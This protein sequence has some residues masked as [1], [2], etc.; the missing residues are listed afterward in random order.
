MS[1]A[2][3]RVAPDPPMLPVVR[4]VLA[5][6]ARQARVDANLVEEIRL[7]VTEAVAEAIDAHRSVPTDER[8]VVEFDFASSVVDVRVRHV[9][10]QGPA[11]LDTIDRMGVIAGIADEVDV[12]R[13]ESGT[14]TISMQWA[15]VDTRH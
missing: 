7:A 8:V 13:D 4:M 14:V 9:A 10:A 6:A 11:R 12:G 1:R 5:S 3:L 15:Q 2:V